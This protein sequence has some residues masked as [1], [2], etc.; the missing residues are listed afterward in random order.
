MPTKACPRPDEPPCRNRC[1][2]QC[3]NYFLLECEIRIVQP[4]GEGLVG[5]VG[6][7]GDVPYSDLGRDVFCWT[8]EVSELESPEFDRHDRRS[9]HVARDLPVKPEVVVVRRAVTVVQEVGEVLPKDPSGKRFPPIFDVLMLGKVLLKI[10]PPE[11]R[12][13]LPSRAH[14]LGQVLAIVHPLTVLSREVVQFADHHF[15]LFKAFQT[16]Q[17]GPPGCTLPFGDVN[18]TQDPSQYSLLMIK[19]SSQFDVN[20]T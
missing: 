18:K 6:P 3:T 4:V 20:K 15:E 19:C 8:H 10:E 13:P 11:P 16:V 2:R 17:G 9:I 1:V 14:R 5:K 12:S 7:A